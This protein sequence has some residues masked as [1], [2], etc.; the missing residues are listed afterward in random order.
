MERKL[1]TIQIIDRLVPIEGADNIEIA[2]VKG[3]QCI[4]KKG[5]F[6][7]GDLCIYFEIDS[8]LPIRDDFEFL[9]KS[10]FKTMADGSEGF[11]LRTIRLRGEI[12]QGL[13]LP[14]TILTKNYHLP[15]S[16]SV[17]DILN[18]DVTE[19]L[20]VKKYEAPIPV[21]LSGKVKGSFPSFLIKTDEERIQNLNWSKF[22]NEYKDVK[23][24]VT[25]K[26]DGSSSTYYLRD[27]DFGV[28]SRNL[29]LQRPEPFIP[30]MIMCNDGIE[31]PKQ[32]N[33]FW[34]IERLYNIEKKLKSLGYNIALQGEVIGEGIQ[35]NKY[36]LKGHQLRI[37]TAFD[38]DKFEKIN[39]GDMLNICQKL[40]LLTVP[41]I[42]SDFTL[43][44]NVNDMLEYA[45]GKS[46]INPNVLREGVVIRPVNHEND[47]KL[48]RVSFK[49][50]SN[51]FLLK[52]ED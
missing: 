14:I 18:Y 23:F 1:A 25:E 15:M 38:I 17:E 40:Y 35:K 10:S 12:S 20:G 5:E 30:G 41:I 9:R 24:Y 48:N 31:R 19:L 37:F 51:K 44:P 39:F 46:I 34:K 43:L 22:Y 47:S 32:E 26:C 3:W 11:R 8:F 49:V 33:T 6:K 45:N 28:C 2:K 42:D 4:V 52:Y 36:K 29:D 13:A 16:E 7:E 21:N 27:N 50:I